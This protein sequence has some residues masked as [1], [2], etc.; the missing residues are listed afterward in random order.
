MKQNSAVRIRRQRCD[1]ETWKWTWNTDTPEHIAKRLE[2]RR[3]QFQEKR[4][5]IVR[6]I[7]A[8]VRRAE[9]SMRPHDITTYVI[10]SP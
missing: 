9:L 2:R 4:I 5:Q 1:N 3:Q 6:T 10:I 7:W 8:R